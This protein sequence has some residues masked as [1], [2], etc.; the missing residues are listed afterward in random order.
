MKWRR[1][2]A[3]ST[4]SHSSLITNVFSGSWFSKFKEKMS[5][6]KPMSAKAKQKVQ[7]CSPSSSSSWYAPWKEGWG[8]IVGM[9]IL[10]RG[11]HLEMKEERGLRPG[12]ILLGMIQMIMHVKRCGWKRRKRKKER[13]RKD[14]KGVLLRGGFALL[15]YSHL[16]SPQIQQTEFPNF[17]HNHAPNASAISTS[18]WFYKYLPSFNLNRITQVA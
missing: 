10:K 1:K 18:H 14:R 7:E 12:K 3:P 16:T 8:F 6:F 5:N 11:S 2:K 4:S 17:T 15:L 13:G 9:I